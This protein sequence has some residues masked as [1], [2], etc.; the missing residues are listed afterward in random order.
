[1]SIVISDL[2]CLTGFCPFILSRFYIFVG[3][4]ICCFG[5]FTVMSSCLSCVFL[6]TVRLL[7]RLFHLFCFRN[8]FV[9]ALFN[10]Y[11][12][13]SLSCRALLI[14]Y[15]NVCPEKKPSFGFW[16]T[17]AFWF[18]RFV[19]LCS[20][21]FNSCC[22]LFSVHFNIRVLFHTVHS[23]CYFTVFFLCWSNFCPVIVCRY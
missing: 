15:L 14:G 7:D 4:C 19:K 18:S 17:L 9:V 22:G 6:V 5:L 11:S 23:Q 8:F 10:T 12:S 21:Y 20:L 1:M 16:V 3:F 2:L 13:C